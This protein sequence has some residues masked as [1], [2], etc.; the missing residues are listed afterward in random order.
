MKLS[1]FTKMLRLTKMI[2]PSEKLAVT[3]IEGKFHLLISATCASGL[4]PKF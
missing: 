4:S 2:P 3:E 1:L